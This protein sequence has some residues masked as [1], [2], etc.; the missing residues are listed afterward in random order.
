MMTWLNHAQ[1]TRP[2]RPGCNRTPSWTGSLNLGRSVSMRLH[3]AIMI[4]SVLVVGCQPGV[5][6]GDLSRLGAAERDEAQ[7]NWERVEKAF[8]AEDNQALEALMGCKVLI[9]VLA[10]GS[11]W[12]GKA[13]SAE[14]RAAS[15]GDT[16]RLTGVQGERGSQIATE[17]GRRERTWQVDCKV[18]FLRK[19]VHEHFM[20]P[21]A[22]FSADFESLGTLTEASIAGHGVCIK[23]VAIQRIFVQL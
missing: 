18:D 7:N 13:L 12:T 6:L 16:N 4:L 19:Q 14:E 22:V 11:P 8:K 23:P 3:V 5:K 15:V 9:L 1:R 17:I 2:S 20:W 21:D 10:F